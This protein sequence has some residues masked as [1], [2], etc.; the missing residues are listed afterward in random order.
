MRVRDRADGGEDSIRWRIGYTG[1]KATSIIDPVA[2]A[3]FGSIPNVI[4]YG[5]GS[6][7]VDLRKE[8]SGPCTPVPS[9]ACNRTIYTLDGFGRATSDS[10]PG[11]YTT[12]RVFD[13]AS[14]VTSASLPVT[15]TTWATTTYQYDTAGNLVRETSPLGVITKMKYNAAT[16]DLQSRW[17]ATGDADTATTPNQSVTA[18][19][20]DTAGHLTTVNID[21]RTTGTTMP[22]FSARNHRW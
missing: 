17:E 2:Y 20:Y 8:Y 16:N 4:A 14:N 3:S 22:V 1:G 12:T 9:T 15:T 10:D 18:Y 21:C 11:G 19:T 6:T 5:T 7:I 13:A